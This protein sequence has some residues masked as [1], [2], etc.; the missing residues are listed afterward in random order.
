MFFEFDNINYCLNVDWLQ[1]SVLLADKDNPEFVCPDGYR[2]EMLPGNNVFQH[3]VIV[4]RCDEA[5]KVLT[6]LWKPYSRKL[7]EY[8]MTAQVGN[9]FLYRGGIKHATDLL[10]QIVACRFNSMGRLDICCDFQA[11]QYELMLIRGLWEGDYYVQGKREGSLFWHATIDDKLR[12][13]HCLSWGSKTSEIKVKCYNKS[14]EIG[15]IGDNPICHKPWILADWKDANF[16]EKKV[17]RLEFSLCSSGQLLFEGKRI[18]LEDVRTCDWLMKLWL[19]LYNRRFV[20]RKNLGKR[21]GHKNEDPIVRLLS[22]P[23]SCEILRWKSSDEL[24]PPSSENA[25]LLRKLVAL[26]DNPVINCSS[27]M[28]E[29]IGGSILKLSESRGLTSYF[30]HCFG[31]QPYEYLNE[32]Y[33]GVGGGIHHV[34]PDPN[35][36][37]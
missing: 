8:L 37:I 10:H 11:N 23:K 20:C 31:K 32:R 29:Y 30:S 4:W 13:P 27:E 16:D 3:R 22:L 28:F 12:F 26:L 33:Q 1:F 5:E 19:S 35:R 24:K 17:W 18:T 36:D 15:M 25:A 34:T 14:R 2:L 7:N 6:L 9:M 21:N